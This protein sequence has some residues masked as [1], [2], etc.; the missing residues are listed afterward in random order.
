MTNPF[1]ETNK[2]VHPGSVNAVTNISPS[3]KFASS[4][5]KITRALPSTTPEETGKPTIA[6]AG[7]FSRL[8]LP[9]MISPSDVITRGGVSFSYNLYAFFVYE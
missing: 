6:S 1:I 7:R 5:F 2:G 9:V 8:Y 4:M 3:S